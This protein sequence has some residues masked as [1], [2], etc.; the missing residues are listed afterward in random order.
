MSVDNFP[1]LQ[2]SISAPAHSWAVVTPSDSA[3]VAVIP[4]FIMVGATGGTVT[5]LGSDGVSATFTAAAGQRL[6]I[7]P[8]RI[9]AT[10]TTATPIIACY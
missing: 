1:G 10:G 8:A 3:D 6:D 9:M 4:K 5:C 2:S 7:R